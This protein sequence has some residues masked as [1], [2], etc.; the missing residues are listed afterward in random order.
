MKNYNPKTLQP[1]SDQF[2]RLTYGHVSEN[3]C[4]TVSYKLTASLFTTAGKMY[5]ALDSSTSERLATFVD[6]KTYLSA[7][8]EHDLVA[9]AAQLVSQLDIE[10][11][12]KI[13]Q[14]DKDLSEEDRTVLLQIVQLFQ[15]SIGST[16]A[17]LGNPTWVGS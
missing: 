2:S 11:V 8:Q 12:R 7:Q 15:T 16:C 13:V 3:C 1:S 17:A 10:L 4:E 5:R 6:S 14:E 9:L